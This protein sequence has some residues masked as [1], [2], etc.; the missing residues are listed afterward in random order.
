MNE[1][2]E[3]TVCHNTDRKIDQRIVKHHGY[4]N[5]ATEAVSVM[6]E[7]PQDGSSVCCCCDEFDDYHLDA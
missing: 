1:N 4:L 5:K 2:V 6:I 7:Y 3:N